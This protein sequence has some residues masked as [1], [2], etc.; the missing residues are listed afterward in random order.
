MEKKISPTTLEEYVGNQKIV[1]S[2]SKWV[3]NIKND[4]HFPKRIC[5]LTGGIGVGKTIL[6]K[7]VLKKHGF[8]VREF[9]SSNLR[10]K[11]ERDLLYQA[12][13]FR[14][15]LAC[16]SKKDGFRKA[17]I[18]D[19]FEN[20]C[21]AT[22]EVFRNLKKYIKTNKS[23][24]IPIIFVGNKYFKSKR[25]LMGTSIYLRMAPRTLKNIQ[26]ILQHILNGFINENKDNI[27]LKNIKKNKEEQ[28]KICKNS[29]RDVRKIIKYFELISVNKTEKNIQMITFKK[30]GQIYSLDRIMREKI[31]MREILDEIYS[32]NMLPYGLNSSYINYIPWVIKQNN[33]DFQK[34][35]CLFLWK[36]IAE[37]FSFYG[38]LKDYEKNNQMWELSDIANL[39]IC[40]GTR[41]TI[42]KNIKEKI[43]SVDKK[44]SVKKPIYKGKNFWWVDLEKGKKNGDEPIDSS[45]YNINLRGSLNQYILGN[46]S[47]K[48]IES[49]LGNPTAW[50]PNNIR[51][52]IQLLKLK[53][54]QT[55][56][57]KISD[58]LVK[59]VGMK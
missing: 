15:V 48:M 6:A 8:V 32:E 5:F 19:D 33:L 14:D 57:T 23:I 10:V 56:I 41:I 59:M 44:E 34:K 39:I 11:Q 21:L 38:E 46:T 50:K 29:G 35:R 20:M 47:F 55:P 3:E 26:E 49:G 53:N 37:L 28:L 25:P 1:D 24:G 54:K 9:I 42:Q 30:K 12:F 31:E 51:G 36:E 22:Q 17:I 13:S 4:K 40:W 18:I 2:L 27:C 45:L 43:Y 16:L 7:L 52:T 58:R